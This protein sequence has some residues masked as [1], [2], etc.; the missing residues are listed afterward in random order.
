MD[1][2]LELYTA[3]WTTRIFLEAHGTLH[4]AKFN[5]P[6]L[7]PLTED[8]QLLHNFLNNKAK[9]LKESKEFSDHD[10]HRELIQTKEW[11]GSGDQNGKLKGSDD[12]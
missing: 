1:R 11:R 3:E 6:V 4:L 2:F 8:I 12:I 10:K 5:N 7:L 9:E